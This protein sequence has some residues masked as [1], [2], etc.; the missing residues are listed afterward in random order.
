MLGAPTQL[1]T[2]LVGE[3]PDAG[4]KAQADRVVGAEE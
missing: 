1:S 4:T 3:V 2:A